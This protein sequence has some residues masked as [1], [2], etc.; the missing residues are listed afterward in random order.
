M[1]DTK[2]PPPQLCAGIRWFAVSGL[3]DRITFSP[4]TWVKV[5]TMDLA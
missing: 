4:M 5:V 2:D 3:S 1:A